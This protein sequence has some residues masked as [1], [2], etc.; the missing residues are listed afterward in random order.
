MH[1]GFLLAI[2]VISETG[3]HSH[4]LKAAISCLLYKCRSICT[5]FLSDVILIGI[6]SLLYTQV[7]HSME[8][9]RRGQFL[10]IDFKFNDINVGN[11]EHSQSLW[12]YPVSGKGSVYISL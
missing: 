2:V 12:A 10:P 11:K 8:A 4:L 9:G 6:P 3:T 5:Y 7:R 1:T